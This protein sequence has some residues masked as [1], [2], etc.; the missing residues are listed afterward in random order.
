[1]KILVI[2]GTNFIGPPVVHDLSSRG[3]EITVFHRGKTMPELPKEV[4][5]LQGDRHNFA[6]FKSKFEQLSPQVVLDMIPFTEKDAQS[7]VST[8]KGIAQRVVAISSQDVYRAYDV[9]HFLEAGAVEPAPLTE[10]SPL[11]SRLY[12]YRDVPDKP[13][14]RSEDYEKILVERVVMNE[15]DLPSTILR[16]PMVY[17]SRD[18]KHRLFSHLKRMD[19]KR[20]AI[21]LE[22]SYAQWRGCWGYVENVA[23]AISLAVTDERAVGRIYNVGEASNFTEAE[24]IRNIGHVAGWKGEVV[25][26]PRSLMPESW[27]LGLNTEQHWATDTTRIR[28]ELGYSEPIPQDETLRRTIEWERSHPPEEASKWV[29]P[30]MLDYASEDAILASFSGLKK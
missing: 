9:L 27:K 23:A 29:T 19:D 26:V 13:T 16:L 6:E 8:F 20:P 5:D 10:D 1:M 15:K 17:G 24:R 18:P 30:A 22:E 11:R 7:L 4:N 2:G 28:T 12:P 3:H 14:G 25:I 21:V